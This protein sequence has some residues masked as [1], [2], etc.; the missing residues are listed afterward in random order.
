MTRFTNA[1]AAGAYWARKRNRAQTH[2]VDSDQAPAWGTIIFDE[3]PLPSN[4]QDIHINGTAL[5]FGTEVAVGA[6]LAETLANIMTYLDAHPISG[7]RVSVNGNGLLI[8]SA[9][10]ADTSI[11]I[12]ASDATVSNSHLQKQQIRARIPLDHAPLV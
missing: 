5:T 12:A 11:V 1:A 3:S 6:T 9:S 2:V 8:Q 7:V 4:G 10:P